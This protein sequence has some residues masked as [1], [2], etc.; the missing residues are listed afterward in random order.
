MIGSTEGRTRQPSRPLLRRPT[1]LPIPACTHARRQARDLLCDAWAAGR[2]PG[3]AEAAFFRAAAYLAA[4]APQQALK[5]A[6][7]ALAYGPR[8][9]GPPGSSA[10]TL[11]ALVP[12]A[13]GSNAGADAAPEP[14]EPVGGAAAAGSAWPAALGLLS[15]ALEGLAD[16]V[17]A[18]L[19]AARARELDPENGEY[20]V[21]LDRLLRRVPEACAAALQV[22]AGVRRQQ[23]WA[24]GVMLRV[25]RLQGHGHPGRRTRMQA[26]LHALPAHACS[27]RPQAGGAAGLAAHLAG[28]R[29]AARPEFLR[30]RPKYYYYYE[31]MRKRIA[32]Q[33]G[34]GSWAGQRG[35][36]GAGVVG[37]VPA[38]LPS[39][40]S[41]IVFIVTRLVTPGP[42]PRPQYPALPEPVADKLLGLEANE[43]DLVLQYPAATRATVGGR[44]AGVG[45]GDGRSSSGRA[46]HS[47]CKQARPGTRSATHRQRSP[48]RP[49]A[50]PT[51][52][53]QGPPPTPPP[54]PNRWSA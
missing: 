46:A 23:G 14:A 45:C 18:A 36:A 25:V 32:E 49:R 41:S 15:A 27:A 39:L 7:F 54:S 44:R 52:S 26:S 47:P 12:A 30:R 19:A 29:E 6:R 28:E 21:A 24:R 43:L 42:C 40:P 11:S 9:E 13:G 31:W 20:E 16:N 48:L 3:K 8:L 17:A 51:L 1:P 22:R 38:A 34:G 53:H 2:R 35:R 5:D 33:V 4:G 37:G 10:G 50:H